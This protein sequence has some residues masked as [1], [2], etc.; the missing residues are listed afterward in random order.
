MKKCSTSLIVREMQIKT[1]RY[2]LTP[3]RISK[4]IKTKNDNGWQGCG[5]KGTLLHCLWECKLI[6]PLWRTI[7]RFLKNLQIELS[8][9]SAIPLCGFYPKDRRILHWESACTSMFI[10]VLFTIA[11]TW[12]QSKCSRTDEWIEKL[13]H[14]HFMEYYSAIKNNKTLAFDRK[15]KNMEDVL[16]SEASRL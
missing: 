11:K 6:Q 4:I 1:T 16:L 12:N 2:H 8:C 10:A 14:I 5:E 7:Q 9:D 13:W 15:W 3:V